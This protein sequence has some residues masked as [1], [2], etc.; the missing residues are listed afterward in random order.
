MSI[1]SVLL[2]FAKMATEKRRC[3]LLVFCLFDWV[4]VFGF[5]LGWF[6]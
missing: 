4:F 5:L 2:F 6:F 1:S 3:F